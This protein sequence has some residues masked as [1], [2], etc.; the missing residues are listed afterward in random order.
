MTFTAGE[1][2]SSDEL[3]AVSLYG[4]VIA[5]GRRTSNS[6]AASAETAVLRV[7]NVAL[8]SGNLYYVT[9][10]V[11]QIDTTVANDS[12]RAL[13][14]VSTSGAATTSST[15]LT[16][17]QAVLPSATTP[18]TISVAAFYVP[19]GDET[20]SVLLSHI[21]NAGTGNIQIQLGATFPLDL[22]VI[23]CG[24]DPGDTGVDL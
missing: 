3:N 19:A 17:G 21:R 9:T 23:D 20:L 7:D 6:T 15:L 1:D 2:L 10:N 11:F 12:A 22:F 8:K 5:R 18:D 13:L 4:A 14:R 24:V 16:F